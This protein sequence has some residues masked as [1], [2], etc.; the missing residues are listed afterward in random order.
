MIDAK[1][2]DRLAAIELDGIDLFV[3]HRLCSIVH[4]IADIAPSWALEIPTRKMRPVSK[5]TDIGLDNEV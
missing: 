3:A 4:H 2:L 5:T 1:H